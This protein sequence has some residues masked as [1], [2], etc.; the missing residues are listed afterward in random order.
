MFQHDRTRSRWARTDRFALS[1]AGEEAEAA[2]RQGVVA[3]RDE[4]GRSS[5][6][7]ARAEWARVYSLEPDDGVYL[8][9]LRDNPR[10]MGDLVEALEACGKNRDDAIRALHR[11]VDAGLVVAGSQPSSR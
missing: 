5:Y 10:K 1:S 7:A 11:L 3:S 2:Y 8:A 9:E 4:A 6:D